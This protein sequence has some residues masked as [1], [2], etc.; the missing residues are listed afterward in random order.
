MKIAVRMVRLPMIIFLFKRSPH[1]FFLKFDNRSSHCGTVEMNPT[2]IHEDVGSI[3]GLA[4]VGQGS[5]VAVNY[6]VGHRHSSD[7][8]FLWLWRRPAAAAP[9]QLLA[10]ELPH[11]VGMALKSKKKD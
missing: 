5:S 8:E 10:C 6:G 9:F 7:L 2:S 11:A 1:N 3:P 4:Q